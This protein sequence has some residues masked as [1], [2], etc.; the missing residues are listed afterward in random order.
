MRISSEYS[1]RTRWRSLTSISENRQ[2]PR[3]SAPGIIAAETSELGRIPN[4]PAKERP[5]LLQ[6]LAS[7]RYGREVTKQLFPDQATLNREDNRRWELTEAHYDLPI[8][9]IDPNGDGEE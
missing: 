4:E 9:I 6:N 2:L 7:S 5:S 8:R 3:R 1:G